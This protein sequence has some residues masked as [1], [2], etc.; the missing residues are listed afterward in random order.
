MHDLVLAV[1]G[2]SGS[3]YAVRLL[4]ILLATGRR[5]HLTLSPAAVQVLAHE[6]G[7]SVDLNNFEITQLLP[8]DLADADER[9]R[10]L[11]GGSGLPDHMAG[12]AAGE[13]PRP[14]G[15]IVYHHFQDYRAGIA[16]GSF[17]TSGMVICPC[18]MGTLASIANGLSTNLIHRAADVHLKER[19]KLVV[20]PRET[21]LGRIQLDNMKRLVDAGAVV[22]PAMPGFYHGPA[23]IRDLVDFVVAR[24]CDQLG[25]THGL[26]HRWGE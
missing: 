10:E 25:I 9:L 21:P 23:T 15:E 20:V 16:S 14:P 19:R 26:M 11:L 7:L 18:S 1:T 12:G 17:L 6:L 2:A 5:I 13:T 24:I 22:L 3:I 8:T 4:Q